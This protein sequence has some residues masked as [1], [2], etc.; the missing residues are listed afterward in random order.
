[1]RVRRNPSSWSSRELAVRQ[2]VCRA[3]TTEEAPNGVSWKKHP[4][5]SQVE[6]V[7]PADLVSRLSVLPQS[8]LRDRRVVERLV[9][10]T[11]K[12]KGY[13]EL[14][15]ALTDEFDSTWPE[16]HYLSPLH[17][18]LDW[19]SD[20][21]LAALGRN[22]VFAVSGEHAYPCVLMHGSL[23]NRRGQVVA[24]SFIVAQF[25]FPDQPETAITQLFGDARQALH[26]L[27]VRNVNTDSVTDAASL[28]RLIPAAMEA[29]KMAMESVS[30]AAAEDVEL[31]VQHW[32]QRVD[33]WDLLAE[34]ETQRSVLK[35]RRTDVRDERAIAAEMLPEQTLIRPLLVVQGD[36]S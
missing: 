15:S 17:P 21:S 13:D 26:S 33:K 29:A 10:A 35:E 27:G 14:A 20:R 9:L 16:S 28:E 18:V 1:L 30:S 3:G 4:Q 22:Q 34:S 36:G 24:A 11:T 7:P 5:H 31:R 6:L 19:I 8:Y 2:L 25:R 23:T 12:K 32:L